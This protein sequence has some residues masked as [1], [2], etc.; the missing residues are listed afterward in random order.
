M[1]SHTSG[2]YLNPS[3]L[4][5]YHFQTKNEDGF[6][7]LGLSLRTLQ[8]QVY[9]SSGQLLSLEGY[10]GVVDWPQDDSQQK[11]FNNG[12]PRSIADDCNDETEGVQSKERW[13]YVKVN[14]DG[15]VVGR[16]VCM[17]DHGS[18][19]SL[20]HQLEEMFGTQS[21]S[22]LRLFHAGSEFSLVYKDREENWK[23]VGDVP[24]KEFVERVT[25]L[26]IA[27]KTE[28]SSS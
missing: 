14:M 11:E 4:H 26:W 7:D 18:Y 25:R 8:P 2:Y 13:A 15:V 1:D 27:R 3:T 23:N 20:V 21:I 5:P 19:S 16:K 10:G 9:R 22:G 12:Y 28:A 24:W 6:I 17:V